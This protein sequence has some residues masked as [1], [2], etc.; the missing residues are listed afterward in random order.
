MKTII[1]GGGLSGLSAAWYLHK[2]HP[3]E[4]ISLFE[5]APRLGGWIESN[6][7]TPPF[8]FEKGPRTLSR[9]RS[10]NLLQLIEELGLSSHIVPSSPAAARRFLLHKGKL[11]SIA[12][13][14]PVIA[15]SAVR[16]FF[17]P[18][19]SQDDESIHHFA[20]RRFGS[21]MASLFFDPMTLGVYAGDAKKLSIRSSF[22]SLWQWEK[23]G[24]SLVKAL[25]N[26][27]KGPS[28]LFTLHGGLERLITEL[29][30]QLP[31]YI[32]TNCAVESI[33]PTGVRTSTGFFAADRIISA[34]PAH[35]I[36]RLTAIPFHLPYRS[37]WVVQMG[38]TGKHLPKK[39]FG[40]LVP[41]QEGE[42]LLG[43]VWDSEIFSGDTHT[44]V[45]AMVGD[46]ANNREEASLI[47][48][49]ALKNHLQVRADPEFFSCTLAQQAIPQFEL[50]HHARLQAFQ[51][52]CS[53]LFPSLFLTGNYFSGAS[54]E[55]AVHRSRYLFS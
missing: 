52:R 43:M 42:K 37:V 22:P 39:G 25:W 51:E 10:P 45:T 47:A 49:N 5:K 7:S 12:S 15:F 21:T 6:S 26:A 35:E 13:F 41:S 29:N 9:A 34:L 33:E 1:L 11:R 53:A 32:K 44:R 24:S 28:G 3:L 50:G 16:E 38:L 46:S 23:K 27:P 55:A 14:W 19:A 40:Y 54:L 8:F 31:I 4:E 2:A 48:T 36:S 20:T 18:A 30:N 17:L